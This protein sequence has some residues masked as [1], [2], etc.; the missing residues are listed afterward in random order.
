MRISKQQ[1]LLIFSNGKSIYAN[2]CI[3]GL[4]EPEKDKWII[5]DGYDGTI[6]DPSNK[7][8]PEEDILTKEERIELAEYMIDLW[9]K[10]KKDQEGV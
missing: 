8:S 6:N 9:T 4:C 3:I 10:F 7:F 1:D 5:F 2:R